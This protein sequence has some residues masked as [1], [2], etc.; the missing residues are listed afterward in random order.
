MGMVFEIPYSL[1]YYWMSVVKYRIGVVGQVGG[2]ADTGKAGTTECRT[3]ESTPLTPKGKQYL[4]KRCEDGKSHD[5]PY[6]MV[7]G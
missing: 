6:T 7:Y 4:Y 5:M 2:R 3:E 1:T